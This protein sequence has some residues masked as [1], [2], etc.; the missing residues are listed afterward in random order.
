MIIKADIKM[1]SSNQNLLDKIKNGDAPWMMLQAE[2]KKALASSIEDRDKIAY[3]TVPKFMN[4]TF[5]IN[6]WKGEKKTSKTDPSK[7]TTY[8]LII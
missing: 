4:E 3:E 7:T 1:F 8:L 2:L 5:G 6:K